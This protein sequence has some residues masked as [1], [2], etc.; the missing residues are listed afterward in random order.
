MIPTVGRVSFARKMEGRLSLHISVVWLAVFMP[1]LQAQPYFGNGI[2][3][4]E[5]TDDSAIIWLRLTERAYPNW[6]GLK[7]LDT[8]NNEFDVGAY[9]ERQ[10]PDGA[11]LDAMEGSLAGMKGEVRL[12]WWQTD[13]PDN[14][15]NTGWLA[16]DPNQDFTRQ[17]VLRDLQANQHYT[18]KL[19]C[20]STDRTPGQTLTGDFRTA[21]GPAVSI[22]LRFV[23]STCQSWK[24]RDKG[25]AGLQIY[26]HMLAL[27]PAFFMHLG[28][29]VY[30][31]KRSAGGDVEARTP[32]LARFHWNRWYGCSDIV[33]FHKHVPSFFI[34]DDHD[35]VT[36]DSVPGDQVG[37]LSW[38]RGLSIFR[39]QVPMGHPTYRSRRW[40]KDLHFW[41]VEGRDYR[42]PN[43]MP[44]GPDKSIWGAEQKAWFKEGVLASDA[45]F[46]ILF[47]PT[48]IVGPDRANKRDNHSNANWSHEGDEIRR[49]CAENQIII[50]SGDR[51]WQYHSIDEETGVHEFSSG[52]S[53][54]DHA[55]GFSM[56]LRTDEHQYLAIAGGFLS[57]EIDP[58]DGGPRLTLRH[59][60]VDGSIAYE[61]SFPE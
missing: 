46:K 31:D 55:G 34:K 22:P 37:K 57:G 17:A 42:S 2:K 25:A 3:I 61:Y 21:A 14:K 54:E 5:T 49:F 13:K 16:V 33:E 56:D 8:E 43:D 20:R 44:D 53:S 30:Y 28:D 6:E 40:S 48:P 50:I 47:S 60:R 52:A 58:D 41:I 36:N 9:G 27:D 12:N 29:I 26:D 1:T 32:E 19:E 15:A 10:F 35:T 45:A 11:Q 18:L 4:G 38:T 39:E 51:H 23:V 59:H 24:T 7:W